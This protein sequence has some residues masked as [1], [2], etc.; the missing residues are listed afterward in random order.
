MYAVVHLVLLGGRHGRSAVRHT[1]LLVLSVA[2]APPPARLA[3]SAL[4]PTSVYP[5]LLYDSSTNTCAKATPG[6]RA[7]SCACGAASD[8]AATKVAEA[9]VLGRRHDAAGIAGDRRQAVTRCRNPLGQESDPHSLALDM[10]GDAVGRTRVTGVSLTL[11]AS[12][13][14]VAPGLCLSR[15]TQPTTNSHRQG[16]D[17]VLSLTLRHVHVHPCAGGVGKEA[18]SA[19]TVAVAGTRVGQQPPGGV[20]TFRPHAC[21]GEKLGYMAR[22][23]QVL[24]SIEVALK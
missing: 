14:S 22:T 15:P 10:C 19:A 12:L 9:A 1:R 4:A 21:P 24:P 13:P 20:P 18:S 3:C 2:R 5:V 6:A 8:L 11:C 16:A 23:P 7:A 17:D